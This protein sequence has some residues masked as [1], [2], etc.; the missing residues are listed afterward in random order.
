[1]RTKTP[2][3]VIAG[4]SGDSGKTL[5]SLGLVRAFAEA[6]R[7][8]A[9]A[10]KGPDYIDAAW[11]GL[12]AGR[13]GRN[14][15]TYLMDGAAIASVL[16]RSEPADMMIVEGNRGLHDGLDPRGSHSTAVLAETLAAPVILVIDVTKMT[17]TV[18]A[19]VLGCRDL[20]PGLPLA[21]VILNRVGTARQEKVIREAV[22]SSTG[23]PVLGA[24]PRLEGETPLPSRHLGLV[25]AA[26]HGDRERAIERAGEAVRTHLDLER[27]AA[28]AG[29]AGELVL[30]DPVEVRRGPEVTIGVLRDRAFSFYYPEN[31]ESLAE[32]GAILEE[33]S[34]LDGEAL[35]AL[36][37]L[38]AGGGFP[39]VHAEEL[40]ANRPFR[41][42]VAR[43]A[44]AG[45]PIYAECGGL[46][47][48]A[49]ALVRRGES[50]PMA[51]V[52]PLTV[53]QMSRPQ[54]HG[55]VRGRV[56]LENPFF[57]EG[58]ELLGHEFHYSRLTDAVDPA[59]TAVSLVKGR[60]V[61]HARDA[62]VRGRVWASYLHLH[63][64]GTPTWAD[65]LVAAAAASRQAAWG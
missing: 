17:R 52:L 16:R 33:I 42:S 51:G 55:Y 65:G 5:V 27:L 44:A 21:G 4:L 57:D 56:E 24:L 54:G 12:A 49:Q 64:L 37:A 18:A 61:G 53:E 50:Y 19:L 60:G 39:E 1:M 34:P 6:G 29:G 43:A 47:Y 62:V 35:P 8:V 45:L 28:I 46:M 9:P 22:V 11:L 26:E 38:Y 14:L 48:L 40:A 10:K 30:P 36:D 58:Q 3:L 63:A 2:R 41:E 23:V 32:R 13:P 7:Q 15:D 59:S 20:A 25:T 31:L